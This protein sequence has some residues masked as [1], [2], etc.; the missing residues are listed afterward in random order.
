MRDKVTPIAPDDFCVNSSTRFERQ[1][2]VSVA[3]VSMASISM[4]L[5]EHRSN[6]I[7]FQ[8]IVNISNKVILIIKWM[9]WWFENKPFWKEPERSSILIWTNGM[10]EC[11]FLTILT[12]EP[13]SRSFSSQIVICE[14]TLQLC[15]EI[16]WPS[17]DRLIEFSNWMITSQRWWSILSTNRLRGQIL[18][19]L[20][21]MMF[22]QLIYGLMNNGDD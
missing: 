10:R 12:S 6:D 11:G 21:R 2:S 7:D 15:T 8:I 22:D 1:A 14:E 20:A 3:S 9:I 13:Q 16:Q 4:V 18:G 5:E 19:K 17:P